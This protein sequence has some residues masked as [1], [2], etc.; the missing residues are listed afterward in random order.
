MKRVSIA[1]SI[2]LAAAAFASAQSVPRELAG[3]AAKARLPSPVMSWCRGDLEPAGS[4]PFAVAIGSPGG[5][6]YL[7][8]QRNGATVELATYDGTPSL[9]CYTP[10]QARKLSATLS[11]SATIEG[12]IRPRWSTTVV[13]GFVDN[14]TAV[15]WQYS[16]VERKFV[17]VG[18]WTT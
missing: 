10:A 2:T 14:T 5:R 12:Q 9:A 1:C 16:L 15:C 8:L 7:V 17:R 4:A 11:R 13:C 3:L 18:G 6:R